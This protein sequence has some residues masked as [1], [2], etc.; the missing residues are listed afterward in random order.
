MMWL[1]RK[2]GESTGMREGRAR[3]GST[4]ARGSRAMGARAALLGL[5]GGFVGF[6]CFVGVG[7]VGTLATGEGQASAGPTVPGAVDGGIASYGSSSSA[8]SSSAVSSPAVSSSQSA[9]LSSPSSPSAFV[10]RVRRGEVAVPLLDDVERMCALLTSCDRLPIPSAVFPADFSACVTK[11]AE[12]M[13]SPSAVGFSLTVRECGLRADSCASLRACAL[14]GASLDACKGRGRQG[15]VGFCDVD[16]RAMTCWHDEVLSV[17]DCPRGS[18]QCIVVDG[19]ASC[20]LG[21]CQ[22]G[23]KAP[24]GDRPSCS[25]SGTHLLKCEKGKLASLDCTAFGLKCAT[26]VDGVAGCATSAPS[27]AGGAKHCDGRVAV[28]CYNGHQVRV[29]CDSAGLSCAASPSA[30]TVGACA[31]P[32]PPPGGGCDPGDKP[33]C[34]GHEIRYCHA[35]RPRAFSCRALGFHECDVRDSGVRCSP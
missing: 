3:T 19:E 9:P 2:R 12:E 23:G 25:A 5:V 17:R 29:D 8:V 15:V 7:A 11:M 21:A 6:V 28:G 30:A 13:S 22:G 35:G 34:E 24:G 14:H 26:G 16:G 10:A 4:G 33:R 27:C 32:P 31:A 18:E 20:T 1:A